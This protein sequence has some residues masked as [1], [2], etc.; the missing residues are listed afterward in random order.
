MAARRIRADYAIFKS[1][2][3]RWADND[4]F[5]HMNNVVHYQLFD[6]AINGW[7]LEVG[8]LDIDHGSNVFFVGETTCR[9][10]AQLRYPQEIEAGFRL[11]R[12]GRSSLT[13]E[14]GLFVKGEEMPAAEGEFTHI[15]VDRTAHHSVA[16]SDDQRTILEQILVKP[17]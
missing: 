4:I 7:L 9:Y 12:L 8:L 2:Q 17:A 3:T 6:T 15:Q 14:I 13:Y 1:L 10:F 11:S 5:G 16:I